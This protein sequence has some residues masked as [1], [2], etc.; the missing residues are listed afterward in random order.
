MQPG[1]WWLISCPWF[2][3]FVGQFVR[4]IN[5]QEAEFTNVIY[6]TRTGATFDKL[7]TIGLTS[8]TIYHGPSKRVFVPTQGPKWPW[9]AP[10]PWINTK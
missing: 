9:E 1:E 2:W 8:D 5:F 10:I 7:T 3:T 4:Q 6:F